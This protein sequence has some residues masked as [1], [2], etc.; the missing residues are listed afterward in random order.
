MT[1]D[2]EAGW[3]IVG[4]LPGA[5][6]DSTLLASSRSPYTPGQFEQLMLRITPGM[7][8]HRQEQPP[9]AL[10]WVWFVPAKLKQTRY[11]G[12]TVRAWTEDVDAANRPIIVNRFFCVPLDE[13]LRTGCGFGELYAAIRDLAPIVNTSDPHASDPVRL[14]L[15][16]RDGIRSGTGVAH[17]QLVRAAAA[18]I[19]G[20]PVALTGGG[21][22][23]AARLAVLDAIAQWLPA[24]ARAWL[25]AGVWA[26]RGSNHGLALAFTRAGR[27]RDA[28]LDVRTGS[29]DGTALSADATDYQASVLTL[30]AKLGADAVARHLADVIDLH[31]R[32]AGAA[33]VSLM[34]LDLPDMACEA[35]RAGRMNPAVL[36]R[37][38]V[39][40]L[41]RRLTVDQVALVLSAYCRAATLDDLESDRELLAA[42]R[43]LNAEGRVTDMLIRLLA[44]ASP[45]VIRRLAEV[46]QALDCATAFAAAL[47]RADSAAGIFTQPELLCA[48]VDLAADPRWAQQ[49]APQIAASRSYSA[50]IAKVVFLSDDATN[51]AWIDALD[52]IEPADIAWHSISGIFRRAWDATLRPADVTALWNVDADLVRTL[53]IATVTRHPER[54]DTVLD[55]TLGVLEHYAQN[56]LLLP[57][58]DV[59][60]RIPITQ[61]RQQASVDFI[62]YCQNIYPERM[63][64]AGPEYHS[65]LAESARRL[66]ETEREGFLRTVVGTLGA[67]WSA[68]GADA[69]L[70]L[71]W[72]LSH[73]ADQAVVLTP[74]AIAIKMEMGN[75]GAALLDCGA[76]DRWL[77]E[78]ERDPTPHPVVVLTRLRRLPLDRPVEAVADL[79]AQA[80]LS[81]VSNT[82]LVSA[83]HYSRWRPTTGWLDLAMR[84]TAI[85]ARK[86][87]NAP[88]SPGLAL[89]QAVITGQRAAS[90]NDGLTHITKSAY[91]QLQLIVRVLDT[92]NGG[93]AAPDPRSEQHE[94]LAKPLERVSDWLQKQKR[95]EPHR[96]AGWL[97]MVS[98]LGGRGG[99][100]KR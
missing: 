37:L 17:D 59:L 16:S 20:A 49:L 38:G 87:A 100:A 73:P 39:Q 9:A 28:V 30:C 66:S 69:I 2:I 25:T 60:Q 42:Q 15:P 99:D 4:K 78:F 14:R 34:D 89:L 71:L 79:V 67:G 97:G 24:G 84:C 7:S 70:D 27:D 3:A 47:A 62:L 88:Y 80:H 81:E 48:V 75:G 61:G 52:G 13:F 35:A 82:D 36:R 56:R 74:A 85:L 32:D 1:T 96:R 43:A 53:L 54:L 57:I 31:D 83:F 91:W 22:D 40:G 58:I 68:R 90:N 93:P 6:D 12:V 11:L 44:D 92:I 94:P 63:L 55:V 8:P 21:P 51:T 23:L 72:E 65:A 98:G 18:L 77:A 95:Q 10:P 46:A 76:I 86:N 50:A 64:P 45:P 29:W 19:A 5:F 41:A 33:E 26:D